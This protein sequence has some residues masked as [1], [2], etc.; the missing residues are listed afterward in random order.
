MDLMTRA[1]ILWAVIGG[2]FL[3]A[4][5]IAFVGSRVRSRR[6]VKETFTEDGVTGFATGDEDDLGWG[7]PSGAAV[8]GHPGSRDAVAGPVRKSRFSFSM[9]GSGKPGKQG[10]PK[11]AQDKDSRNGKDA[12]EAKR[13]K[14]DKSA[15]RTV[16]VSPAAAVVVG[17]G[18]DW[19]AV[20]NTQNPLH[21]QSQ[22]RRAHTGLTIVATGSGAFTTPDGE[23][24]DYIA[25]ETPGTSPVSD[26]D[27]SSP[28]GT[29]TND[30]W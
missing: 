18:D 4:V 14:R 17:E 9:S 26:V 23:E 12:G 30:E 16:T 22:G 25:T 5:V 20:D 21:E 29:V 10:K 19:G 15:G 11:K 27:G 8:A 1:Y 7:D 13:G 3:G 24:I 28:F 2:L 6:T